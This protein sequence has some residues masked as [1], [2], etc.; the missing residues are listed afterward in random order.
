MH[1]IRTTDSTVKNTEAKTSVDATQVKTG[2]IELSL[3]SLK[4]VG[5]G[6]AAHGTADAAV[7]TAPRGTW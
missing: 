2:P 5:G 1:P 3:E 7:V 6:L 4:H